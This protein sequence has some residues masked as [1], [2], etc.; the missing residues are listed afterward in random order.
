MTTTKT[1]SVTE[2]DPGVNNEYTTEAYPELNKFYWVA[3][4]RVLAFP[5]KPPGAILAHVMSWSIPVGMDPFE[6]PEFVSAI[7]AGSPAFGE[8][9]VLRALAIAQAPN[10]AVQL[11]AP[12]PA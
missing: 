4:A 9:F 8:D 2:F 7:S 12:R 6:E 5:N 1:I 3:R 11:L 10:L